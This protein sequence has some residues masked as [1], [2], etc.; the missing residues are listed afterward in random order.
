MDIAQHEAA[1]RT[2]VLSHAQAIYA[3]VIEEF[4]AQVR[5]QA[6][7]S[8]RPPVP[9]RSHWAQEAPPTIRTAITQLLTERPRSYTAL[10]KDAVAFLHNRNV[11]VGLTSVGAMIRRM[12]AVEATIGGDHDALM[13]RSR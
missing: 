8:P 11:N 13:L 4:V 10:C 3:S 1:L 7:A 12:R 9:V 6:V 2:A 5:P